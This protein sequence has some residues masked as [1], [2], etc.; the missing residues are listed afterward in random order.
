MDPPV[1]TSRSP[2]SSSGLTRAPRPPVAA[3]PPTG[4]EITNRTARAVGR[5]ARAV[6]AHRPPLPA[7]APTGEIDIVVWDPRRAG[8]RRHGSPGRHACATSRIPGRY[9]CAVMDPRCPVMDPRPICLRCHGSRAATSR[10]SAG[11]PAPSWIPGRHVTVSIELVGSDESAPAH[12]SLQSAR[13]IS[14]PASRGCFG[15]PSRAP[16]RSSTHLTEAERRRPARTKH[17]A[18]ESHDSA[19]ARPRAQRLGAEMTADR[20]PLRVAGPPSASRISGRR[21]SEA[22]T[23]P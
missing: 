22:T 17:G 12:R 14:S 8:L 5:G 11:M 4:L 18:R 16:V 9:A 23:T 10:S 6:R 1:G 20:G 19:H 13:A 2:S 15:R 7:V 21:T 3:L